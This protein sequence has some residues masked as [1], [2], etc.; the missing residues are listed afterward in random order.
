MKSI[1]VVI[2]ANVCPWDF[3]LKRYRIN[4]Q[5]FKFPNLQIIL[6]SKRL[7]FVANLVM[8]DPVASY[9]DHTLLKSVCTSA[10]IDRL[11]QEAVENRFAA[12]C[13]PPYLVKQ[14]VWAL[15]ETD[16]K[17]AT[18]IGFPM[19]YSSLDS[20]LTETRDAIAD[21]S[22]ELDVVINIIALKNGEWG[23]LK[24][25]MQKLLSLIHE[26]AKI[27]KVI[28]ESGVLSRE[29]LLHCCA[30]YG[31]MDIDFMKTSTGY[32]EKGASVSDVQLMRKHLPPKIKIKASGGIRH[33]T[34]AAE[35]I[36]A[37][38]SRLGCSASIQILEEEKLAILT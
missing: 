35:L 30:E 36:S 1:P 25:E 37:G 33:Y 15:K 3:R 23:Y 24:N 6:R 10:D 11:C 34:F 16:V 27:I 22:D 18:V 13:I 7:K 2:K 5:I 26:K 8:K 31:K 17:T 20:K 38:A 14:A 29:E 9:I 19:G 28:V 32:A 12:V 4:F 21:G